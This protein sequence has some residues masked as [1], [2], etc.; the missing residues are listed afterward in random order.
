MGHFVRHVDLT[1]VTERKQI[2]MW[3]DFSVE[4]DCRFWSRI[5]ALL[6]G[7]A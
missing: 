7:A 1:V 2:W 5:H 6:C 4:S 3:M